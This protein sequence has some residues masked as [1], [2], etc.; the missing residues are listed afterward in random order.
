M[1]PEITQEQIDEWKKQYGDVFKITV[2]DKQCFL[3]KPGRK[4][5]S[6]ASSAASK[7]PIKFNEILLNGCW[8]GGDEDIKTNDTYFLGASA[9]LSELIEVKEAELVKL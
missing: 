2:E 4:T 6:F 8:L 5:L 9:K 7:D 1:T 3:K